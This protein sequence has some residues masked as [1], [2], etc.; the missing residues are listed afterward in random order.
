M[1][2]VV[3]EASGEPLLPVF[4]GV[5]HRAIL[6]RTSRSTSWTVDVAKKA[7]PHRTNDARPSLS[8]G[9]PMRGASLCGA[10]SHMFLEAT[11]RRLS[12]TLTDKF[13]Q[14]NRMEACASR[15]SLFH[16]CFGCSR[17]TSLSTCWGVSISSVFVV[18]RQRSPQQSHTLVKAGLLRTVKENQVRDAKSAFG[19]CNIHHCAMRVFRRRLCQGHMRMQDCFCCCKR[20]NCRENGKEK[21]WWCNWM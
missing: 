4:N 10:N 16:V 5:C 18:Q 14:S 11:T 17:A 1:N 3:Q 8:P 19:S 2:Y 20:R 21:W 13:A 12:C 15:R 6:E 9:K 7:C